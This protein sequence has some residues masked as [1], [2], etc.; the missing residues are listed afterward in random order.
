MNIDIYDLHPELADT[1]N[2]MDEFLKNDGAKDFSYAKTDEVFTKLMEKGSVKYRSLVKD[3]K[4]IIFDDA[5]KIISQLIREDYEQWHLLDSNYL[6]ELLKLYK[7]SNI[8]GNKNKN[9]ESVN[10]I[11]E[12]AKDSFSD[13]YLYICRVVSEQLRAAEFFNLDKEPIYTEAE[14]KASEWY[15]KPNNWNRSNYNKKINLKRKNDPP[16]V[17]AKTP[18][19]VKYPLDKLNSEVYSFTGNE[20]KVFNMANENSDVPAN[21][22]FYLVDFEGLKDEIE[23]T[24]ELTSYD[25]RV[26][27]SV[28]ALYEAGNKIISV[29]QIHKVMGNNGKPNKSQLKNI[30]DSITK[31]NAAHIFIA[32]D[33]GENC[34]TE[35]HKNRTA[36]RYDGSLLPMERVSAFINGRSADSAIHIFREPPLISFAVSRKQI[37]AVGPTL[38]QSPVNK[39]DA[40]LT[41][42]DYL[43]SE[44]SRMKHG[45][46][47]A[48]PKDRNKD[49]YHKRLWDTIFDKCNIDDKKK[50]YDAKKIIS[51]LLDYYKQIDF[52][53]DCSIDKNGITVNY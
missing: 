47:R 48:K 27:I 3:N 25:K 45:R 46:E 12:A 28:G 44:I 15:D 5:K 51:R 6:D 1:A 37:T 14:N 24:K 19:S 29:T 43:I 34:E 7:D 31:L 4:D 2:V 13:C 11:K 49:I 17:T 53:T 30:N 52:I 9:I 26:M 21:V 39:T 10:K 32:N 40:T 38:L 18:T 33:V 22:L 36:F 42:E 35:T 50:R 8:D 16:R 41:L 23:I 20:Q